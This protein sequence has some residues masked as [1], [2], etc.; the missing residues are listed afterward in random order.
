MDNKTPSQ[1]DIPIHTVAG[2]RHS[3]ATA[4]N[5]DEKNI[6]SIHISPTLPEPTVDWLA[7]TLNNTAN[8]RLCE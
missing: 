2:V 8:T 3:I 4:Y 6:K 5:S 1:L 7:V